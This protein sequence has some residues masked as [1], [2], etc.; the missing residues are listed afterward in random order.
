MTDL[1]KAKWLV[2]FPFEVDRQLYMSFSEK[3]VSVDGFRPLSREIRI[4][5]QNNELS[6]NQTNMI[7]S[8]PSQGRQVTI[9]HGLVNYYIGDSV[10]P[11]PLKVDRDLYLRYTQDHKAVAQV[12]VPS[13]GRQVAIRSASRLT[14][15]PMNSFRPLARQI[16]SYTCYDSNSQTQYLLSFRPLSRQIGIYTCS[17]ASCVCERLLSNVSGHSRGR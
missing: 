9:Q 10:F 7:V 16:G 12:S 14:S 1:E 8:G 17:N 13:R 6:L 11:A 2:P 4:Y 15:Q 5:T 3:K